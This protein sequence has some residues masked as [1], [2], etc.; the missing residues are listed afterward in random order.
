MIKIDAKGELCPIPVIKAKK[1]LKEIE[2]NGTVKIAVDNE[3]AKENLEKMAKEM[4]FKYKSEKINEDHYEVKIVKGEEAIEKEEVTP[5]KEKTGNTAVVISSNKMGEGNEE[6]GAILMKAFIYTLTE[7]EDLP[8]CILFYN[9]GAKLTIKDSPVLEDL[10]R[11]E[12]QGVEIL[13]CGTCL[14]YYGITEVLAVGAVTNMYSI[15]EKMN[16]ADKLI[17]P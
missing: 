11:L 12:E 7:T 8:N 3:I 2:D 5:T 14:N 6:L 17:K 4:G 16:S 13:T 9:G 15:V 10:K 1:A